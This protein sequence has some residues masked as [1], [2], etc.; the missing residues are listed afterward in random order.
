MYHRSLPA[1]ALLIPL[2]LASC[3]TSSTAPQPDDFEV[4]LSQ[5]LAGSSERSERHGARHA[6]PHLMVLMHQ[7]VRQVRETQGDDAARQLTSGLRQ[8][9]EEGRAV[10]K[11]GDRDAMPAHMERV[12]AATAE[13]VIQVLGTGIAEEAL[14]AATEVITRLNQRLAAA[15]ASGAMGPGTPPMLERITG[16]HTIAVEAAQ[17][18]HYARALDYASR[19]IDFGSRRPQPN[20]A[21][22]RGGPGS[23][24]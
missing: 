11:A 22:P 1:L 8:L 6:P 12:R 18:G 21:G 9:M 15:Q 23:G 17:A 5:T 10:R 24:H 2:V 13:T 3:D 20:G 7:A 16:F 4:D 19:V 14:A